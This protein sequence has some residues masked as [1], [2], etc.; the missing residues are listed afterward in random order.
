MITLGCPLMALHCL[1]HQVLSPLMTSDCVMIA[2]LIRYTK[3]EIARTTRL[4]LERTRYERDR[5]EERRRGIQLIDVKSMGRLPDDL[6]RREI[7]NLNEAM[8]N[9]GATMKVP[10]GLTAEQFHRVLQMRNDGDKEEEVQ[11]ELCRMK[12][13]EIAESIKHMTRQ[14]R[15]RIRE[16]QA[17]LQRDQYKPVE[18]IVERERELQS[19]YATIKKRIEHRIPLMQAERRCQQKRMEETSALLDDPEA[20]VEDKVRALRRVVHEPLMGLDQFLSDTEKHELNKLKSLPDEARN[21]K[22]LEKLQE[23]L[24]LATGRRIEARVEELV[25]NV[26]DRQDDDALV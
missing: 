9:D 20:K 7:D 4:E 6:R 8:K 3:E 18:L 23:L 11:A 15:E 13:E 24:A 21:P 12:R 26:V 1:P 10:I 5:A 2:S 25:V 22:L 16:R 17:A 14:E 19:E